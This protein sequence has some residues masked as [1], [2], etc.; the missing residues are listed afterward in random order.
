MVIGLWSKTY[1][2]RLAQL[3]MFSSGFRRVR[4]DLIYTWSIL[5]DVLGENVRGYFSTVFYSS[6]H[7]HEWKLSKQRRLML[8]P[9]I[10]LSYRVVNL[11]NALPAEVV[12]SKTEAEF[13][14]RLESYFHLRAADFCQMCNIQDPHRIE[15][16]S[17]D[18]IQVG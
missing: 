17:H 16:L 18:G 1:P 15:V 11:W 3:N 4:G 10:A 9:C 13:K 6:T 2:E 12:E 14:Q 7:G 5:N 8:Y